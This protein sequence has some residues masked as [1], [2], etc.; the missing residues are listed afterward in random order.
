MQVFTSYFVTRRSRESGDR[1]S[2]SRA[3]GGN[4]VDLVSSRGSEF[5]RGKTVEAYCNRS[6]NLV[7]TGG[8]FETYQIFDWVLTRISK[9]WSPTRGT[10]SYTVLDLRVKSCL[11]FQLGFIGLYRT[12]S[13][14]RLGCGDA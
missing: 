3:E 10:D 12:L 9:P 13:G 5:V 11:N 14:Q 8:I 4:P 6:H 7:A 1:V 2:K